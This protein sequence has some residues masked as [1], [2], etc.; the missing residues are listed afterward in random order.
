LNEAADAIEAAIQKALADGYRTGD[1]ADENT[2]ISTSEMG[3]IIAS[4]ILS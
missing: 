4:N 2:P 1:L 3:D